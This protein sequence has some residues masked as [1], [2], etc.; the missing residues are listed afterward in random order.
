MID[1][2]A[3]SRRVRSAVTNLQAY[4]AVQ[5]SLEIERVGGSS[6]QPFETA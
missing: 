1:R 6:E 5:F 4:R 3:V 2:Q